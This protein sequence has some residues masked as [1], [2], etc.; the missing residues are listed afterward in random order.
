MLAEVHNK[1]RLVRL[2]NKVEH[3]WD[4]GRRSRRRRRHIRGNV[5]KSR[6]ELVNYLRHH[7]ILLAKSTSET[8]TVNEISDND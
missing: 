1:T 3:R 2:E 7:V 5:D 6:E 4:L 8:I